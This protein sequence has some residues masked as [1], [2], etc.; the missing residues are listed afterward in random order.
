[1]MSRISPKLFLLENRGV[2]R[3][4]EFISSREWTLRLE[5]LIKREAKMVKREILSNSLKNLW[6]SWM[7]IKI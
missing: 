1:M 6:R 4:K 5:M 3:A 7:R 2:K